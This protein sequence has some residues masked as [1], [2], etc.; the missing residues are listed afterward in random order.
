[1]D[2]IDR[3]LS[4]QSDVPKQHLQLIGKF[5]VPQFNILNPFRVNYNSKHFEGFL[6]KR[7][8][9]ELDQNVLCCIIARA[10]WSHIT[11]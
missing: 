4:S 5:P 8:K 3:Y 11:E 9:F 6:V 7:T 2:Y 10:K 1:M